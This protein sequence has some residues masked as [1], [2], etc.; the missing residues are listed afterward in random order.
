[1][2]DMMVTSDELWSKWRKLVID[3]VRVD[4]LT[5]SWFILMSYSVEWQEAY[6]FWM[7][8][9]VICNAVSLLKSVTQKWYKRTEKT[10]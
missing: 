2:N 5:R 6:K 10:S 7:K 8:E 1:M 3:Y 9:N 4:L